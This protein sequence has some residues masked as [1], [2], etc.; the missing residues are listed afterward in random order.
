MYC[1]VYE[2]TGEYAISADHG[3]KI[4]DQIHP[5]LLE[6]QLVE[7]DFAQ[8]RVFATLFFNHAIGQL[9]R[10]IPADSL[11]RLVKIS[12]LAEQGQ[13]VLSRVIDNAKHYYGDAHYQAAVD[14]VLQA[15][16]AQL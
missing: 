4:F 2:I 16:A 8:V 3:Q 5:I 7:L 15:F 10:D 14:T 11:N 13:Q 1:N 9:L 6:D 12:N